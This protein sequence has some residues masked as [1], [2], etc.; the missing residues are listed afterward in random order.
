MKKII[1]F[2]LICSL[3]SVA[4]CS[5]DKDDVATPKDSGISSTVASGMVYNNNFTFAG[6]YSHNLNESGVDKLVIYLASQNLN[7]SN[8]SANSFPI[9]FSTP[10]TLGSHST[11]IYVTFK[12]LTNSDYVTVTSGVEII[13][14][15]MTSTTVIGRVKGD[16]SSGQNT[17][18]GK[19][20]VPICF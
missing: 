8:S 18:N 4:S 2:F 6:G 1:Q 13:I 10:K 7:C 20:E 11:N 14:D 16:D 15:S 3:L 19:F 12:N 17:I 9:Y 5:T